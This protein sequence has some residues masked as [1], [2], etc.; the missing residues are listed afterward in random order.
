MSKEEK[1]DLGDSHWHSD[2]LQFS[3][4]A[5]CKKT[6]REQQHSRGERRMARLVGADKKS[7]EPW[8]TAP[9]NRAKQKSISE[10][11]TLQTLLKTAWGST[12]VIQDQESEATMGME[13]G[14]MISWIKQQVH[15]RSY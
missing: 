8:I 6:S 3:Q 14:I 13:T 1:G 7:T 2:L 11:K 4:T 9:C 12:P 5:V 15:K 10:H